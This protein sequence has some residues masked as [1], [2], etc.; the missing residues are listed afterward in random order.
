MECKEERPSVGQ[1]GRGI[2]YTITFFDAG[3]IATLVLDTSKLIDDTASAVIT[4]A[5]VTTLVTGDAIPLGGMF[6]LL[7]LGQ[8]TAYMS[9]DVTANDMQQQLSHLSSLGSVTVSRSDITPD[10]GYTW[11]VTF[12]SDLGDLPLLAVD[13][14]TLTGTFAH[15]VVGKRTIGELPPFDSGPGGLPLG[16]AIVTDMDIMA[17]TIKDLK[18]GVPYYVRI[19]ASNSVGYGPARLATPAAIAPFPQAPSSPLDVLLSSPAS[20]KINVNFSPPS[21]NGGN[22]IDKYLVEWDT[23]PFQNEVQTLSVSSTPIQEVQSITTS[24]LDI[25]EQQI[26][27]I[28]GSAAGRPEVYEVQALQCDATGGVFFLT[29]RGYTTEPI[30]WNATLTA[31]DAEAAGLVGE[32]L[33]E[34]LEKL[35]SISHVTVSMP[36]S[37]TSP[38]QRDINNAYDVVCRGVTTPAGGVALYPKK[39]TIQF[40]D[41]PGATGEMPLLEAR[42]EQLVGHK[43]IR[44]WN[45]G[46]DDQAASGGEGVVS[47]PGV[48]LVTGTFTLTFRGYTTEP[49]PVSAPKSQ[50]L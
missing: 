39:V 46:D 43:I 42:V 25:N 23:A 36:S 19:A 12:D 24:A 4:T 45:K 14:K 29:F 13:D 50:T 34:K 47:V 5:T 32:S 3:D 38:N 17:Y 27:S 8:R 22:E 15:V 10:G 18:Q 20:D 2:T 33:Q 49:I 30:M 41:I 31:S 26:V 28:T 21:F 1:V 35:P 6:S 40:D 37:G 16:T 7:F 44:I 9:Y 48:A 11:A